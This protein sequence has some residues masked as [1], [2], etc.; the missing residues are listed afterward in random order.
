MKIYIDG[1]FYKKGEAKISVYDHGLLYGDG[2]FEGIRIYHGR[3]FKLREHIDRLYRSAKAILLDIHMNKNDLENAIIKAVEIN[4]KE[5]GYIRLLV[6]RGVGP[7][8]I[9]PMQCPKASVI[10][11]V[12]DIQVYLEEYY[13]QGI[14]VIT[15]SSRRVAA[16]ALDPRIKS[17]N[18]LNNIMARIEAINAD[19]QEAI[20]LNR[21]G[22][23]TE[24]TGDNVFVVKDS[25]L[26]TPA[27]SC[28]ALDGITKRT[29]IELAAKN[30]IKTEE[31]VLAQ[32][33]LYNADEC[34]LV[35]T[36]AEIVPVIRI[37]D[38]EIGDGNPGSIT[39][40]LIEAFRDEIAYGG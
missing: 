4:D 11:I 6:T 25:M 32:Y 18:Y 15:A 33:D 7:L 5:D 40:K 26:F 34:F 36:G 10:I 38:R 14:K 20:M 27:S 17:L 28:G 21:D 35:G 37:D 39:R 30:D 13:E 22:F 23:V 1:K 29:I 31:S 3:I 12:D 2:V 19:C 9:N 16:D 8:G 24:C